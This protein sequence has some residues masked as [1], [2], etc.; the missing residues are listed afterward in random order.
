MFYVHETGSS[1]APTIVLLHGGGLSGRMWGSQ[2]ERLA[3]YHCLVPDLP[4]QGRSIDIQPFTLEDS[5]QR[6]AM[7]IRERSANQRAHVVGLSLGGAVALT[8]LRIAPECVDHAILSGTAAGLGKLLGAIG[9]ASAGLYRVMSKEM[10]VNASYKQFGIPKQYQNMFKED[11]LAT[12]TP[13]FVK[14]T[15]QVLMDMQLPPRTVTV[16][17]LV[18]V[19]EKETQSAKSAARTLVKTLG[20]VKGVTAPGVGHVWNLQAPDL[21]TDMIRA[22][23]TDALLPS[24]LRPL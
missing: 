21:F 15:I 23:V 1:D 4:E 16:P 8:L 3:D 18:V 5:A 12:S 13:E 2:L 14:R 7:L 17:T 19:G 6:V 10:L 22:W 20:N 11:L 24:A 9:L